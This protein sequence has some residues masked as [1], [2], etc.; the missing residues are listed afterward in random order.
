MRFLIVDQSRDFRSAV[1]GMLRARWPAAAVEEWD[2]HERGTPEG[3]LRQGDYAAVLMYIEPDAGNSLAWMAGMLRDPAAPPVIL[4]T[5]F[6][7]E[8]LAVQGLKAGAADFLRKPDLTGE[9]LVRSIEDAVREQEARRAE[10]ADPTPSLQRT[11]PLDAQ[12][13]GAPLAGG[14]RRIPSSGSHAGSVRASS[15]RLVQATMRTESVGR[16]DAGG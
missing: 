5:E 10:L 9:R 16:T 1:S 13:I 4:L 3:A 7:G 12:R 11:L 14:E 2:P 6:G 8:N 15:S